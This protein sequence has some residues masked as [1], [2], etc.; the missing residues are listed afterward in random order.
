MRIRAVAAPSDHSNAV[1]S[2]ELECTPEGLLLIYLGLGAYSEGYATG[3]LT[4]GTRHLIPWGQVEE[5]R[6]TARHVLLKLSPRATPHHSL[7][8]THFS[9]G[10]APPAAELKRRRRI[11]WFAT[12]RKSVV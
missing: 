12:D 9:S 4:E 1:G 10:D 8:L 3:A 5:V 11:L 6:A 7:C 2:L